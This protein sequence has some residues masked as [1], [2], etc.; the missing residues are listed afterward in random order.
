MAKHTAGPWRVASVFRD[1]APNAYLVLAP[2]A[3]IGGF[4]GY[5]VAD[6]GD[7][8]EQHEA[9]ARLIA[10][11]PD[12]FAVLHG[13]IYQSDGMTEQDV[14]DRARAILESLDA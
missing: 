4:K 11:A 2:N 9:N 3:G 12:M 13:M 6:C 10:A 5:P 14:I 7:E 8:T 1:N